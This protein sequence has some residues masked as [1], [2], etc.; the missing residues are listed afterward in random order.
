MKYLQEQLCI[1]VDKEYNDYI[2]QVKKMKSNKIIAEAYKIVTYYDIVQIIHNEELSNNTIK[3][4][5][6]ETFPVEVCFQKWLKT[7]DSY[8]N[9]L[10]NAINNLQDK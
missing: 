2:E 5:L 9:E 10:Y 8:A 4:L 6:E 3:I 1:K 7:W